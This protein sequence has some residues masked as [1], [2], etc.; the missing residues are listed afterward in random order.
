[1]RAMIGRLLGRRLVAMGPA[2]QKMGQF[3]HARPDIVGADIAKE[4]GALCADFKAHDAIDVRAVDGVVCIDTVPFA[5]ASIAHVHRGICAETG[6]VVAVKF[7]KRRARE[8]ILATVQTIRALVHDP[9]SAG[10]RGLQDTLQWLDE[11]AT[12]LANEI[13]FAREADNLVA[14][15][16]LRHACVPTLRRADEDV[17]VMTHIPTRTAVP[18][19]E[20]RKLF[21]CFIEQ[22]A[23]M[24]RYHADLHPGNIG[25]SDTRGLVLFD[26][27]SVTTVPPSLRA[28]MPALVWGMLTRDAAGVGETMRAAGLLDGGRAA[29]T[30]FCGEMLEYT[31]GAHAPTF[32]ARIR[33]SGI[34]VRPSRDLVSLMRAFSLVEGTCRSIDPAFKTDRAIESAIRDLGEDERFWAAEWSRITARGPAS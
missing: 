17:I 21:A 24:G 12:W 1:M 11:Y 30:A 13:D 7:I 8:Q 4:L 28:A 34:D 9:R 3:L 10:P 6:D 22:L 19:T 15:Y 2:Y 20:A 16:G 14:M 27:A 18:P 32:F 33:A 5:S 25:F 23:I 26:F 29:C 31:V